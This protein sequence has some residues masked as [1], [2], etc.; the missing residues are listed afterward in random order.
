MLFESIE[1]SDPDTLA[2]LIGQAG[3]RAGVNR[4]GHHLLEVW[5]MH[6]IYDEDWPAAGRCLDLLLANGFVA[7]APGSDKRTAL[8][9]ACEAGAIVQA[10]WLFDHY[11]WA[12]NAPD[13]AGRAPLA[14]LL[15]SPFTPS[16]YRAMTAK[17]FRQRRDALSVKLVQRGAR[18]DLADADGNT[19]L[20]YCPTIALRKALERAALKREPAALD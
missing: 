13:D 16:H 2:R 1:R 11:D 9:L 17:D 4:Q 14:T 18:L 3:N 10:E 12:F 5:A 19:A 6:R 15:A 20:S 8:T 7:D